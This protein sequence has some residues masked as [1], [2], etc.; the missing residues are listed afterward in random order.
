MCSYDHLL[1]L[2]APVAGSRFLSVLISCLSTLLCALILSSARNVPNLY[3]REFI[4]V[5]LRTGLFCHELTGK[6]L[7]C[8]LKPDLVFYGDVCPRKTDRTV[9]QGSGLKRQLCSFG[10]HSAAQWQD[11][12]LAHGRVSGCCMQ[13]V[14]W[15]EQQ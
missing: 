2:C 5:R 15:L 6:A 13:R 11:S 3:V 1:S 10:R 4:S 14:R 9:L 7:L 12:A 8:L